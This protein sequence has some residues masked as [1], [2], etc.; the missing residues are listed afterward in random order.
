MLTV[1]SPDGRKDGA[2]V[3]II[4]GN[5]AREAMAGEAVRYA[6]YDGRLEDLGSGAPSTF[7]PLIS[8]KWTAHFMWQGRGPMPES[9]RQRLRDIVETAHTQGQRVRFWATPD[10]RSEARQAMWRELLSAGVD[11]IN[12][13]D[14]DGLQQFLL[15]ND[16]R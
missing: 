9:E 16:Y 8:D 7:I 14:L 12:T 1:F 11:L 4:S 15:E 3:V 5:R 6:G 10:D 13:D 2:I